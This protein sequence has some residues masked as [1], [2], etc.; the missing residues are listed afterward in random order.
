M[1]ETSSN[2]LNESN[3]IS[4]CSIL[5]SREAP[6]DLNKNDA[7]NAGAKS[8]YRAV[9][10]TRR[11]YRGCSFFP[12]ERARRRERRRGRR[13]SLLHEIYEEMNEYGRPSS[14]RGSTCFSHITRPRGGRSVASQLVV[15][16]VGVGRMWVSTLSPCSFHSA[17]SRFPADAFSRSHQHRRHSSHFL[18]RVSRSSPTFRRSPRRSSSSIARRRL[19]PRARVLRLSPPSHRID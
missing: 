14:S 10:E 17:L 1:N 9:N 19:I 7:F 16:V 3:L 11:A 5:L 6:A 8:H 4:P 15:K 2:E 18:R 12:S 13:E